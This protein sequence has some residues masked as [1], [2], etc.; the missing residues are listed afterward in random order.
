M[1][2]IYS[3]V[4]SVSLTDQLILVLMSHEV[5]CIAYSYLVK[6]IRALFFGGS[7]VPAL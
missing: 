4:I 1:Y 7:S 5:M 3:V 2:V 6:C